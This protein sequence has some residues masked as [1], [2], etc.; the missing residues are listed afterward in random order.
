M[1]GICTLCSKIEVDIANNNSQSSHSQLEA[2]SQDSTSSDEDSTPMVEKYH[3]K[4]QAEFQSAYFGHTR[5]SIFWACC[6][7]KEIKELLKEN[8][9]IVSPLSQKLVIIL[10]WILTR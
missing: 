8:K 9:S 10:T 7:V 4:Q 5:F 1:Q 3:R 6:Y 2:V